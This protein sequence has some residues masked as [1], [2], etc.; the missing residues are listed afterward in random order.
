MR[1]G[2]RQPTNAEYRI[3]CTEQGCGKTATR[4]I[5]DGRGYR[6]IFCRTHATERHAKHMQEYSEYQTQ[7]FI[8]SAAPRS[9]AGLYDDI[10]VDR[11]SEQ[12]R[13]GRR[14]INTGDADPWC[15]GCT[16]SAATCDCTA[17]APRS[18]GEAG[19]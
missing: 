10:F 15:E 16:M 1:F 4:E 12:C 3:S 2:M 14:L 8:E 17:A 6:A 18:D 5:E 9:D 13:C 11:E 19:R 7:Q